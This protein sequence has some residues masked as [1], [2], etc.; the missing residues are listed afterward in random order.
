MIRHGAR[1]PKV[2]S[3]ITDND[4][5]GQHWPN[6]DLELTEVGSRQNYL[7]GRRVRD[8]LGDYLSTTYNYKEIHSVALTPNRRIQSASEV[9]QGIYPPGT[10]RK[11][12][13]KQFNKAVPPLKY[14]SY[15]EIDKL[16]SNALADNVQIVPVYNFKENTFSILDD[17]TTALNWQETFQKDYQIT[18]FLD[19]FKKIYG[20][21]ILKLMNREGQWEFFEN[22]EN[23]FYMFDTFNCEYTDSRSFAAF[24][25]YGISLKELIELHNE[26]FRLDLFVKILGGRD[27]Y[28]ARIGMSKTVRE[29][30]NWMDTR[31]SLDKQG[32]G[33]FGFDQS[34][35]ILYSGHFYNFGNILLLLKISFP[36]QNIQLYDAPFSTS[37]WIELYGPDNRGHY[38]CASDYYVKITFDDVVILKLHYPTFKNVLKKYLIDDKEIADFCGFNEVD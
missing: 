17:C 36:E 24:E 16:C 33:Y 27:Y 22:Y 38:I 2:V 25:K 23:V 18:E 3:N 35:M 29:I 34:K 30:F 7:L 15:E 37:F 9:L 6:G 8:Y 21:R 5:F 4:F 10:R 12:S 28:L 32:M 20:E 11:L 14:I 1:A 31:I 19:N 26:F 13:C